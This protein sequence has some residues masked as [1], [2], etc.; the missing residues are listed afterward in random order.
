MI[1]RRS[2]GICLWALAVL[3]MLNPIASASSAG[4]FQ[5]T[6][7]VVIDPST[8]LVKVGDKAEIN[9]TITNPQLVNGT[10]VCFS[11]D[12]FPASG[13]RTSFNPACSDSQHGFGT[14]LTVEVTP[15]AAPQTVTAYVIASST[16]QSAQA[17]LNLSV[18]PAMPAWIPWLGLMLFFAVLGI[19]IFWKPKLPGKRTKGASK[20]QGKR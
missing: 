9:V 18:Q 12:G 4:P 16:G 3:L 7:G 1:E 15:A 2:L 19:A 13:F 14:I 5:G 11:L 6:F 20:K 17:V 8:V 10:Q